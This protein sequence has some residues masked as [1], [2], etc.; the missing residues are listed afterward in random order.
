MRNPSR[1]ELSDR[2][3]IGRGHFD[4]DINAQLAADLGSDIAH[5]RSFSLDTLPEHWRAAVIQTK[6]SYGRGNNRTLLQLGTLSEA[7]SI[8]ILWAIDR[9]VRAGKCIDADGVRTLCINLESVLASPKAEGLTSLV[10]LTRP[11]W[12]RLIRKVP[13]SAGE[14]IRKTTMQK[15]VT[16]LGRMLNV[17]AYAYHRVEWW[18]PD[19]WN[20]QL[21]SRIPQRTHEPASYAVL[22]FSRITTPWLR[23][24]VKWWLSRNLEGGVYTW[25]TVRNHLHTISWFQ[26]YIDNTDAATGPLLVE[27]RSAQHAAIADRPRRRRRRVRRLA[28]QIHQFRWHT[29]HHR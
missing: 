29:G 9:Q 11:E 10:D 26:R 7:I 13:L 28:R 21:D 3:L 5:S 1:R 12:E 8:E 24:A 6:E 23:G 2:Q 27:L 4:A 19:L 20:P 18:E 15:I 22:N 17:L 25:G 16:T 14:P